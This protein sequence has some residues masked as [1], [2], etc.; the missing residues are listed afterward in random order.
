MPFLDEKGEGVYNRGMKKQKTAKGKEKRT[1]SARRA[2]TL[3]EMGVPPAYIADLAAHIALP[4]VIRNRLMEDYARALEEYRAMGVETEEALKRLSPVHLGGFYA[5]GASIWY[6]L[7]TAAKIYP[8]SMRHGQMPMFRLSAYLTEP[9]RPALLQMALTFTIKRF[10]SFATTV[11]KGFFWHYL[12][13]VKRRFTVEEEKYLPCA[14][15]HIAQ[16]GSQ[17]FR[18]LYY[19]N[20]ISVEYFHGLTDGS[21]GMVFLKT[22][23]AEYL[24]LLGVEVAK[25]EGVWDVDAQPLPRE[26]EDGFA[27]AA[28]KPPVKGPAL[29][30][31]D[32]RGSG[33]M[34]KRALQMS[35]RLAR[36][37]PCRVLHFE[38]DAQALR[39]AAR[40]RGATVTELMTALMMLSGRYAT[41]AQEGDIQIQIPVNMRRFDHSPTV[42][43]DSLYCSVIFPVSAVTDMESVLAETCRQIRAKATPAA[44]DD[45]TRT[46]VKLTRSLKFVPLAVKEPVAR[47][48]YG[49]L[50]DSI[51]SNTLSNL[52]VVTLP[53]GMEK[54]VEKLDFVLGTVR[55]NRAACSMVTCNGRAVFTVAKLTEDPSF[56]EK[57]YELLTGLGLT[58]RVSGSQ[59]Y[60]D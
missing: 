29:A 35:G 38:M 19:Q 24:R 27:L 7:D 58:P 53:P 1:V 32:K 51:F 26:T 36:V 59:C 48:V 3:E 9:V 40:R 30:K 22:L 15:L 57:L 14:P 43:N 25:D 13:S 18:T 39:E 55:T 42:R 33:F 8:L 31:K 4:R 23:T 6:P 5:H 28:K 50:G 34:G 11:K 46:A 12:D 54:W 2:S 20:R 52:G 60:E 17:S 56:E 41:E 21:G 10:P 47:L 45:M 16:S 37:T 49:F 44:M